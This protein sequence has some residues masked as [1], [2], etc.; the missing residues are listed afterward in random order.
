MWN[1]PS[2]KRLSKIPRMYETEDVPAA[3][4]LV[5]IHFFLGGCDWYIVE[6]D[7]EDTFFGY[8]ILNGDYDLAEWGYVNFAELKEI[9]IRGI[10]VDCEL[11]EY[12]DVKKAGEIKEIVDS[13]GI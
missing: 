6:Y 8:A 7:G 11:E 5:H 12:W 3:D 2:K 9:N 10:E 13:G 4:K 1:A